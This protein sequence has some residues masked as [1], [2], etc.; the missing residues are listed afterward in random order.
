VLDQDV[1]MDLVGPLNRAHVSGRLEE[2]TEAV[3]LARPALIRA[4]A[5]DLVLSNFPATVAP[6]VLEAAGPDPIETLT[7]DDLPAGTAGAG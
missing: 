3:L 5:R 6:D 4:A 2:I 7:A 1:P